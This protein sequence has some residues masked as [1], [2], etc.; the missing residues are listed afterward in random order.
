MTAK[1]E[2]ISEYLQFARFQA[3]SRVSCDLTQPTISTPL[4]HSFVVK[5]SDSAWRLAAFFV[6]HT[7]S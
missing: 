1:M 5:D 7:V 6:Q 2:G 3:F 4:I